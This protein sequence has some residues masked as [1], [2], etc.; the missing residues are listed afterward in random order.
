MQEEKARWELHKNS[1]Y[2]LQ[3]I[4]EAAHY[5]TATVQ[6][7]TSH[8]TNHSKFRFLF[9]GISILIGYLIPKASF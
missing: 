7:L 3:Q 5:R 9:N 2:R 1:T 4:L 8:L 6:L